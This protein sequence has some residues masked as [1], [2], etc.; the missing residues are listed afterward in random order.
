MKEDRTKNKF[1][2]NTLIQLLQDYRFNSILVRNFTLILAVLFL[3]FFLI[4]LVVTDRLDKIT[5]KEVQNVSENSLRQTAQRMD[6]IMNEVIQI[7]AQLSLDSDIMSYVLMDSQEALRTR[8]KLEQYSDI[9]SYVDSIYV[10]SSKNNS[11]VTNNWNGKIGEFEDLSWYN[12]FTERIYAPARMISRKKYNRYPSLISYILPIRLSQMQFLG[13]VIVNIDVEQLGGFV[14]VDSDENLLIVDQHDNIIFK[15]SDFNMKKWDAEA[16]DRNKILVNE[17]A[18]ENYNYKYVSMVPLEKYQSYH[19]S[20]RQFEWMMLILIIVCSVV[21]SIGISIYSYQPVRNIISLVQAPELFHSE[22]PMEFRKDETQVIIQN[23]IHSF[24]SNNEL[25]KEMQDYLEITNKAQVTALQ[26]QISPHFLYNTLENIRWKVMELSGGDNEASRMI[27]KLSQLLRTSLDNADQIVPLSE[28][29]N[30]ARLYIDIL[31]L[32]YESKLEVEWDIEEGLEHCQ[33]VKVV[34]QP[35]IEN[36]V[37]HGIKPKREK[38]LIHISARRREDDL[39]LVVADN[40]IGMDESACRELNEDLNKKYQLKAEHIGVRNV[41]QRLK[42]ILGDSASMQVRSQKG[43][44]TSVCMWIP[45][46]EV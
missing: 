30:N 9:F 37:Y 5:E 44:G 8:Q 19:T 42:L 33:I 43:K 22:M 24:Y 23:I 38:G 32:R 17:L 40:G 31:Q 18:S 2:A 6:T 13:G 36:A 39:E 7:S 16:I 34:L 46:C 14:A 28:E 20:F 4:M 35:L 26:A 45:Y 21:A 3:S 12:D 15:T 25:K 29:I 27:L 41:N 11:I 1:K 10:Y